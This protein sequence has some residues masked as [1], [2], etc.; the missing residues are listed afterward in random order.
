MPGRWRRDLGVMIGSGLLALGAGGC[1]GD[2]EEE[3]NA[4]TAEAAGV[5]VEPLDAALVANLP[6]G[7]TAEMAQQGRELFITCATC[8]GLDARGTQ[9]G[10]SLR[11]GE[12]IH[13]SGELAEI[14]RIT[15]EGIAEPKEFT[16]PMPVMGGGQYTAEEIRALSAYVYA[17]SRG[18]G[19]AAPPAEDQ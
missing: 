13:G 16:V 9:L 12:W 4:A 14:E 3:P 6:Q 7:T 8:H 5:E 15:R 19:A 10:P 1:K 18:R 17:I 11:D 2:A